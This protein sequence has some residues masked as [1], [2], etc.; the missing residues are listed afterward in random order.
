[1]KDDG[2]KICVS[3]NGADELFAGY[4]HHYNL[5]YNSIKSDRLKSIFKNKWESE[6]YP[7]LRNKEYK[8]LTKKNLQSYFTL[9]NDDYLNLKGVKM[10]KD[11]A[12][13][14]ILKINC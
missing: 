14:K 5:Y 2:V 3:G 13:S 7:L 10:F 8:S 4:Y 9:L 11:K 12:F 6:I 1:M